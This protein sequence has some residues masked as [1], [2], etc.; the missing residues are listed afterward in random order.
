MR[1]LLWTAILSLA[2]VLGNFINVPLFFGVD[3]VFGSIAAFVAIALLGSVPG[4]VVA[5]IAGSCTIVLWGHPYAAIIFTLEACFVALLRHRVNQLTLVDAAYWA[6]LGIPLVLFFYWIQLGLPHPMSTMIALKQAVNGILNSAIAM[7]I[8]IGIRAAEKKGRG[9]SLASGLFNVMLVS[10]L[11]PGIVLIALETRQV[12]SDKEIAIMQNLKLISTIV[13]TQLQGL[14]L[15][16]REQFISEKQDGV[17]DL[18]HQLPKSWQLTVGFLDQE[19]KLLRSTG[20]IRSISTGSLIRNTDGVEVWLPE[21]GTA[22][23]MNWRRGAYYVHEQQVEGADPIHA[24]LVERS[25]AALVN[26]L[27]EYNFKSFM[28]LIVLTGFSILVAIAV[29]NAFSVPLVQLGRVSKS[30]ADDIE[31]GLTIDVPGSRLEEVKTLSGS[32]Q[33]MAQSLSH[34]FITVA[35]RTKQLESLSHQLS[36]YLSPQIYDSI[37]SGNHEVSI[38]TERK[39]LT[40]FFSDL[41]DFTNISSQ[42]QPEDLTYILNSYFTEMSNIAIRHGATIDKFIGDAMVI[43]F[44][45]P[46]SLG[47]QEDARACV[48]MAMEMQTRMKDLAVRWKNQG[49][50]VPLEMRVGINTG[51]CNVGNFGSD[52]RMDYTIIGA[53]VNIAARLES[54]ADPGGILISNETL[55]LVRDSVEVEERESIEMKGVRRKVR[56]FAIRNLNRAESRHQRILHHEDDGLRV[57]LEHFRR[58]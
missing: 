36:K 2:G 21:R 5:A 29:S 28:V 12:K 51:Y 23:L 42:L 27:H 17:V 58:V 16:Q 53:E 9:A 19:N 26:S 15:R 52:E 8:V 31:S 55:V 11:V 20:E 18:V 4:I 38:A 3:F 14:D 1:T 37:F 44:G 45:D 48:N 35:E 13:S 39:K 6:V 54:A 57:F 34:N 33:T 22:S 24:V 10:I 40:V 50:D 43:F 41:K 30:L 25:A 49:Y 7:L 46:K 32:F 47:V 56:A